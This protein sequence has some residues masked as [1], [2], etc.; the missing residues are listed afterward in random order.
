MIIAAIIG[1]IF[2]GGTL[3]RLR[4]GVLKSL[5]PHIFGTQLS[6]I[7]WAV[8]TGF[9]M[10][11]SVG[12]PVWIIALLALSNFLAMVMVGTGQY[13]RDVPVPVV[14]DWLGILRTSIASTPIFFI[15]PILGAI[16]ASSGV[17]HAHLYW[18]GFRIDDALKTKWEGAMI[19]EVLIGSYCWIVI[20][21]LSVLHA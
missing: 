21:L 10:W 5:W 6:R 18:L 11:L 2:I 1:S 13:L 16:Y 3:Y 4:G 14:P 17:S 15:N 8:P 12:G 7:F 20:Y 19:G 9:V